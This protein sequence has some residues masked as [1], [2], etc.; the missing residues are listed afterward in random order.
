MKNSLLKEQF[1][2]LCHTQW[3]GWMIYLFQKS[4]K[5]TDGSV[6]IPPEYVQRWEQQVN[7]AYNDLCEHDKNSDRAEADRFLVII[8]NSM[9][10]M[11]NG[12]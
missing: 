1:A 5:Q 12:E 9:R 2:E 10:I 6:I 8:E 4:H 7:T 3:S 11:I